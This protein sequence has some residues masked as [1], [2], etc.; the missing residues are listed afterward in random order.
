MYFYITER[1]TRGMS[2]KVLGEIVEGFV[3]TI[4]YDFKIDNNKYR[5]RNWSY[6]DPSKT[7]ISTNRNVID[8]KSKMLEYYILS[9]THALIYASNLYSFN[10]NSNRRVNRA[11]ARNDSLFFDETNITLSESLDN[12]QLMFEMEQ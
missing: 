2:L 10:I 8:D 12:L 5:S 1:D 7:I 9:D 3:E 6:K 4:K 11:S